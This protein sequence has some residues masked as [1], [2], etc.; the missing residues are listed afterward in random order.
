[1]SGPRIVIAGGGTGGHL[2]PGLAL[3]ERLKARGAE[4][5]FVGTARGIEARVLPKAGYPLELIDVAGLKR[6]GLLATARSLL[7]LPPAALQAVRLIR[8]LNPAVVV[9]VGGYASGPVVMLASLLGRPTVVLEQNS[10][11]G[12]TNRLLARVARKV[13]TAFPQAEEYFP[14]GKVELLG[15]PIRQG[16]LTDEP[17][18]TP[19]S[20][21]LR[22][23]V[24]GG[25]Q[26]AKA[27]NQ[28]VADALASWSQA[29][30]PGL[31]L[32]KSLTLRH[33]TGAA[34]EEA[35]AAR[36]RSFGLQP[37]QAHAEAFI[38]D[39]AAAYRDCDL[40]VGR[41]GA[42]TIAELT[43]LGKPALLIPFPQAA[44]DH[45][46]HNALHMAEQGAAL[47]LRQASTT[48]QQLADALQSLARDRARLGHMAAAS[49]ALGRPH[50]ADDIAERVLRLA[51][52]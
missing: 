20:G 40:M 49:R 48:P 51:A 38:T 33:Q 18:A 26:G 42:T 23:L 29:A 24:L 2:F 44:D 12:L 27:V 37:E 45:Q 3:A 32:S 30:P 5:T 7:R 39:M 6:Q 52:S 47:L 43:A 11:P 28:L 10:I 14:T 9:G 16:L 1:M 35:I 13:Y 36:Y 25:S 17:A 22:V 8:R 46:T 4:V 15:N 34:E 21:P 19:T 41:A 50:A 31:P